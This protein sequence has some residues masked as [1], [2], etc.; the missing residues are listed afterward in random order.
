VIRESQVVNTENAVYFGAFVPSFRKFKAMDMF[1]LAYKIAGLC[2]SELLLCQSF[3]DDL[4]PHGLPGRP[5]ILAFLNFSYSLGGI[6][7]TA[8]AVTYI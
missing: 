5:T 6:Q 2:T 1:Y 8:R 4:I 3:G 7:F